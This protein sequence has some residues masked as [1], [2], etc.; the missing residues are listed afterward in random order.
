ME[1]DWRTHHLRSAEVT[2][3]MWVYKTMLTNYSGFRLFLNIKSVLLKQASQF[4]MLCKSHNSLL[5]VIAEGA[6]K[7]MMIHFIC[8]ALLQRLVQKD[9]DRI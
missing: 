8:K 3:S 9:S 4:S 1:K 7:T 5:F 6:A 2:A